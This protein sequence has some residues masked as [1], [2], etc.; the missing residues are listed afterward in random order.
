DGL[1]TDFTAK[2][3]DVYPASADYP[4]GYAMNI[5]DGILRCRYRD[6]WSTPSLMTPGERV[7]IRIEPFATCNR[8]AK[9]HRLRLDI[10]SSNFPH[11]DVNPN[12]GE[13]EGQGLRKMKVL[14]TVH[15]SRHCPSRLI[16]TV[17]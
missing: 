14:N 8:F 9:G 5:T 16:L 6:D 2:F 17:L 4:Q 12:S 10:A 11:F 13:P 15:M 7:N 1:D 3:V